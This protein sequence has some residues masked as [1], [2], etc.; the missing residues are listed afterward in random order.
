MKLKQKAAFLTALC[1]LVG[2]VYIEPE[3]LRSYAASVVND[4][5]EVN[6]DGWCTNSDSVTLIAVDN[7]G[8]NG[9]RGMLVSD[10]TSSSDGAVSSKGLYLSGGVE[11]TYKVSVFSESD[12]R[13][14][15]YLRCT[16]SETEE[17]IV[18]EL[19]SENVRAGKWTS[20]TKSFSAPE[21]AY[22][23]ELKIVTDST[24]DFV[25]DNVLITEKRYGL[26]ADAAPAGKGLKDE[27]ADYFRVGNILNGAT[28]KN[29]T[30]TASFLKDYNVVE[31]ENETKP[32]ATMVKNGSTNTDIKVSLNSCAA[33][34]DFAAKNGIGFRGHTFVWHGQMP[35]WFFKENF[36]QNANWV[37][38]DVM[39]QRMDS[40]IKNMFNAYQT[41]YPS[42]KLVAY[43][44]CNECVSDDSNRTKNYG[45]A[46]E[47]GWGDGKSPWVQIYGDN[48][49][50]EQAFI[51]ANKYA[52]EGCDLY[53]NDYNEYWGHKRD[54]IYNMCKSLYE[55]GLLDGVGMQSHITAEYTGFTGVDAYVEA[56]KKYLSI[57]CDVQ[58]TELD[59]SIDKGK[60]SDEDQAKKYAAL[61]KA[62]MDWNK[63]PQSDGR[64]TLIQMWG[65]ND[66]NNW[67]KAENK[68]MLY[69][70]NNQP[71]AAYNA[72][73]ALVP[74]NEWG[75]GS[76]YTGSTPEPKVIDG[77]LFKSLTV[78]D[79][80][81]ASDWAIQN[82]LN[83]GDKVYGDRDITVT[84]MPSELTSAE[85]IRTACDSK[86]YTQ[87]LALF[88]AGED[89]AVYAAVDTR[90]NDRL[91]WLR[92]WTDT[93]A[94]MTTSN[95]VQLELFRKTAKSGE[96][97]ELGTN[98]GDNN[99]ANYI[100][101]AL[102]LSADKTIAS[103][104][105][106]GGNVWGD[107]NCDG[108]TTVADAV[109]ILQY[110]S[111]SD[112]Y[113]L[114]DDGKYN[115]DVYNNGDGITARDALSIQMFDAQILD[116]LPESYSSTPAT[117]M[118][119]TTITT[120]TTVTTTTTTAPKSS[121][122]YNANLQYKKAPDS[123]RKD[124]AQ[125]GKVEKV[126]YKT[127]VYNN[128]LEKSAYVYL[129]YG[130]DPN[131]QYNIMYM[132]HGGGGNESSIFIESTVMK[133][134]LDS[135]IMN[136]DI[137][138]TIVV[139]PTFNNAAGSDMTAN[140]KNFWKELA[141]D[142]VPAVESKY[143]TYAKSTSPEDLKASRGHRAFSGFS[144]GSLTTWYVFLNDLDYFEYCM[145]LSGDCWAGNTAD[146]KA[147]AV[148]DAAKKSGYK[149]NEY[150]LMCATGTKD[151]AYG[152]MNDQINSMK[153]LTD[154]FTYTSDFSKGNLYFLLCDG[155]SHWWDGY[156]VDYIYD[157][158]PYLYHE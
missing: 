149:K 95:D 140:A 46:R 66:A 111:N 60:F 122:N 61:F 9:S 104:A 130:Y 115:A 158:M 44:V 40:Y 45:G 94:A 62:A 42:M 148:A 14:R 3:A 32:D 73:T 92:S 144:M 137:E 21:N 69:D 93:G 88:T 99:S 74:E 102:P 150:F 147:Q 135:M 70:A 26:T 16:D 142:V 90:V 76:K 129:P 39:N 34:C 52:P 6:Y 51:A 20:L 120:T 78:N 152:A 116:S 133:K 125:Q 77:K 156:I 19:V 81:N 146:Q 136:G 80:V 55:K 89:I 1:T 86:M 123:Y 145:P 103:S 58:A 41:Q 36:D 87:E 97:V 112:R 110:I 29:S 53:Y 24:N 141:K 63:N 18:T 64:V 105:P 143:S 108:K 49:F 100:V 31:C 48:S 151:I 155:G 139:T 106:T 138:P 56:M 65:P 121:F 28:I 132:M 153:K 117:T 71:K 43:D 8:E 114:T 107:A 35:Q 124:C 128:N 59:V 22:E 17:D 47:P 82:G 79:T 98:G 119:T 4:T 13:F 131:K 15:I 84:D 2:T 126:T 113:T 12:E 27:F 50:V 67:R 134:Y 127:T 118:T 75:D 5:F 11:Y 57:G 33:I 96:T 157:A 85:I 91:D 37:S 30:I 25:F 154:T 109:A 83:V 23:F 7:I 38:K 68:C 101:F 54:C 10:R 72:V